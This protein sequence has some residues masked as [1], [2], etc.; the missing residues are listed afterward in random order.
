MHSRADLID[1]ELLSAWLDNELDAPEHQRVS[2]ALAAQPA[3]AERLQQL[4][5]ANELTRRHASAIDALPLPTALQSLLAQADTVAANADQ[6]GAS[7][8]AANASVVQLPLRAAR[9]WQPAS[10]ALAASVI[11][12]VG[13][14]FNVL[15]R[16]DTGSTP[17]LYAAQLQQVSSG[18]E[19]VLGELHLSPRFTFRSND[20]AWCRLYRLQDATQTLDNVA[21]RSG[22]IADAANGWQLRASLPTMATDNTQY[23]P[24]SRDDGNLDAVLDTLMRGAPLP[25]AEEAVL[26]QQRWNAAP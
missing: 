15:W 1:D 10:L 23:L 5:L 8:D 19:L 25:A 17:D 12:T 13:L 4:R 9:R 26:L 24:A 18:E 16:S 2:A 21:C 6:R 20:G 22:S 11:L 14:A 7:A 3:L